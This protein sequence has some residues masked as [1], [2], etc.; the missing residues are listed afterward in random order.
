LTVLIF[1]LGGLGILLVIVG[2]IM[3]AVSSPNTTAATR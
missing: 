1:T 3:F 2:V